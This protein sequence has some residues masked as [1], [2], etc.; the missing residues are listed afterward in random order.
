MLSNEVTL[1]LC[2]VP[3]MPVREITFEAYIVLKCGLN[4]CLKRYNVV[5][6]NLDH[7]R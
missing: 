2:I 3:N 5:L 1:N 4:H 6:M 7:D